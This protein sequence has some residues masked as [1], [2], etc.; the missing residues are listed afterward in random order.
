M[1]APLRESLD[2]YLSEFVRLSSVLPGRKLGWLQAKRLAALE[3]FAGL[4]FPTQRDEDWKYTSVAGIE[5][6]SF[7]LLPTSRGEMATAQ[8]DAL[9]LR[10]A[11]RLVF[12]NGRLEPWLSWVGA[13]PAG[14]VVAG[15]AETLELNAAG[16]GDI[17]ADE[18]A[19][20]AFTALNLAF[21]TDGAY[22]RLPRGVAVKAPIQLLF[23]A[24]E[25][26]LAIQPHNLVVAEEGSSAHIVEQ[27]AG[28]VGEPYFTNAVTRIVV[29]AGAEVQHHK[30][31]Q[32]G[33]RAFHIASLSAEQAGDSRF[34]SSSLAFGAGL[35]RTGIV[36]RLAAEGAACELNGL[37]LAD[38]RQHV[39]HHTAIEHLRPHG[40]SREFYKGVLAGASRAVFNGR[41]VVH[42]DAQKSDA[43]QTN[44]NLLLSDRAEIDTKPQLEIWAD[45]VKCSHGA[46]VG[47]LDADEIF[48][49]RSRGI[50]EG[51][52]KSLLTLAFAREVV[53]RVKLL[54]LQECLDRLLHERLPQH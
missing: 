20:S 13:L 33:P 28:M 5:K 23:V 40:T 37:Y 29:G 39:D 49:L 19:D 1:N 3:R 44:R 43:A 45:D 47:Q 36:V 6:A 53:D 9:G 16:L 8:V 48:Y 7:A 31:Q 26:N 38:G 27:H 30:L 10:G 32:E 2:R 24:T 25:A 41:V 12:V 54:P 34:V 4:G 51:T 42:P 11:H 50:D 17:L 52:A 18:A 35:S 46:T 21:M 15:L 14:V 22:I